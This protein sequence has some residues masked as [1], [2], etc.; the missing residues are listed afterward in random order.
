MDSIKVETIMLLS[1]LKNLD[2]NMII[3]IFYYMFKNSID[4]ITRK[5]LKYTFLNN[6]KKIY[7][8][9]KKLS[10]NI[11]NIYYLP[12]TSLCYQC[13]WKSNKI[14]LQC[15]FCSKCGNYII[16]YLPPRIILSDLTK[17][18]ISCNCF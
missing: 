3:N 16:E 18:Y 2:N 6:I 5:I 13:A 10:T 7:H 17:K 15:I 14:Q 11:Q 9:N 1:K 4:D 12:I 8:Y